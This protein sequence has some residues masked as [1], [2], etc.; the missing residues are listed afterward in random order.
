MHVATF[1]S[2]LVGC[3]EEQKEQIKVNKRPQ[4]S[5]S[6]RFECFRRSESKGPL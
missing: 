1:T 6:L 3:F 5:D 4:R 2:L